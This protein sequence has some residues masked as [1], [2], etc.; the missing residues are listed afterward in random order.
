[1]LPN[2]GGATATSASFVSAPR[3][4]ASPGL[5]LVQQDPSDSHPEP[6]V[7]FV[8]FALAKGVTDDMNAEEK[9]GLVYE[10]ITNAVFFIQLLGTLYE[11]PQRLLGEKKR[12]AWV[13]VIDVIVSSGIAGIFPERR[14]PRSEWF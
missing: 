9:V 10:D 13:K 4:T 12:H 14:V 6:E 7:V 1:M 2:P 3:S 8:V 5:V 11:D